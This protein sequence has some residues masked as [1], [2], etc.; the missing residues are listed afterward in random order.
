MNRIESTFQEDAQHVMGEDGLKYYKYNVAY[1]DKRGKEYNFD[2]FATNDEDA[3]ERLDR[4][5][6]GNLEVTQTFATYKVN[7]F[8]NL[9]VPFICWWKNLWNL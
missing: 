2:I 9:W 5:Q 7:W 3:L 8:T 4:I 6:Q 1:R